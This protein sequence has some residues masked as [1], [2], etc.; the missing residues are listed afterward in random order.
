MRTACYPLSRFSM[1]VRLFAVVPLVA[2]H[3][4]VQFDLTDLEYIHSNNL[5]YTRDY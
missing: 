1:D 3:G 4:R 2:A 5:K